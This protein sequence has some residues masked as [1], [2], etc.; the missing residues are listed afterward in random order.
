MSL[1]KERHCDLI[2]KNA[3]LSIVI[4]SSNESKGLI[5]NE[6]KDLKVEAEACL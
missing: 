4:N 2:M 1:S 5:V 6:S 3:V